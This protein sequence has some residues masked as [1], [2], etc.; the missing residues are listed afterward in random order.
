M[1]Q[2]IRNLIFDK[3]DVPNFYQYKDLNI[4]SYNSCPFHNVDDFKKCQITL[5]G[6]VKDEWAGG[7]EINQLSFCTQLFCKKKGMVGPSPVK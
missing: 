4:H 1:G 5:K 2:F 6:L 3:N 7:E